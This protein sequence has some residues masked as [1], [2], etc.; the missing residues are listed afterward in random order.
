MSETTVQT[1]A[2]RLEYVSEP[3]ETD[4]GF[5]RPVDFFY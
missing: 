1:R 2:E 4:E 5:E 3:E